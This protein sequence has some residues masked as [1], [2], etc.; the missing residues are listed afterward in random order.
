ML[1]SI[2]NCFTVPFFVAF[3]PDTGIT[4]E[5]ANTLI[6]FIFMLDIVLN[7]FTTYVNRNGEEVTDKKMIA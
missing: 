2:Y 5:I 4:F 7:F 1:L 3:R 6:D